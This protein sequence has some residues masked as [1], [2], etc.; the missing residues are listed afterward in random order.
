LFFRFLGSCPLT[1]WEKKFRAI[2]NPNMYYGASFI[3]RNIRLAGFAINDYSL[4]VFS[5]FLTISIIAI[6]V[7]YFFWAIKKGRNNKHK[8]ILK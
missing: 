6:N 4:K 3:S 1:I 2:A 7:S 8:I 5:L